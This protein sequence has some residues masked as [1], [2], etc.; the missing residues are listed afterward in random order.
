MKRIINTFEERMASADDL[1]KLLATETAL[2]GMLGVR[3][4]VEFKEV[5]LDL[6]VALSQLQ[7]ALKSEGR[8]TAEAQAAVMQV[9]N[10]MSF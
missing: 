8:D 3:V 9:M 2:A 7:A 10:D 4:P 6:A 1:E 5:H